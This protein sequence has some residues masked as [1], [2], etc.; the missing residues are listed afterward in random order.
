MIIGEPVGLD[1]VPGKPSLTLEQVLLD[2]VAP[3]GIP[4][5]L[6]LRAGHC[7]GK[8]TLPL[9]VPATLDADGGMLEIS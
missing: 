2:Q 7:A 6:G 1:P 9:G 5:V 4:I 3:L 8:I